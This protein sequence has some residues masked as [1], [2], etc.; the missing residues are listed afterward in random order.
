[1]WARC[2]CAAHEPSTLLNAITRVRPAG[3]LPCLAI[4]ACRRSPDRSLNVKQ[5]SPLGCVLHPAPARRPT[6]RRTPNQSPI[7][8]RWGPKQNS[9]VIRSPLEASLLLRYSSR[10]LTESQIVTL[11]LPSLPW[12]GGTRRH[13]PG[14]A[15]VEYLVPSSSDYL[16][17]RTYVLSFHR[18]HILLA[19]CDTTVILHGSDLIVGLGG[20]LV[21][22]GQST[23]PDR[24][25]LITYAQRVCSFVCTG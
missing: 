21:E 5:V 10:M 15:A 16:A 13:S 11:S 6:A 9:N 2:Q 8:R 22:G 17:D 20:A 14:L 12:C 1:M 23:T 3:P 7:H 18:M 25:D 4:L 19:G 24:I